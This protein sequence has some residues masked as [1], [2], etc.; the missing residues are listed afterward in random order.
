MRSGI[1]FALLHVDAAAHAGAL[2][3][4]QQALESRRRVDP[5]EVAVNRRLA[6]V[7]RQLDL[8]TLADEGTTAR[9]ARDGGIGMARMTRGEG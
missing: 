8:P 5:D 6:D 7:Y 4:A 2:V 1:F 3:D 9:G